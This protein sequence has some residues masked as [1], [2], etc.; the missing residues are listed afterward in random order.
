VNIGL[1]NDTSGED[2]N[3]DQMTDQN[4]PV[5]SW[6]EIFAFCIAMYRLLLPQLFLTL[7]VILAFV[8]L[9]FWLWF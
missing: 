9:L 5:Y 4:Q 3:K 2:R 6:K 7:L 1:D 8:Y